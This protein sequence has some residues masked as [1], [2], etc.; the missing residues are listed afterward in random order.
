MSGQLSEIARHILKATGCSHVRLPAANTLLHMHE[1]GSLSA[2][3]ATAAAAL[4]TPLPVLPSGATRGV[5]PD[6][7][8]AVLL[9]ALSTAPV[10]ALFAAPRA[11]P[12]AL[13]GDEDRDR[14]RDAAAA[15]RGAGGRSGDGEPAALGLC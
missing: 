3:T 2:G 8:A 14:L 12:V 11:A 4:R 9:L 13:A 10:A 1:P 6:V 7:V 5:L 15:A